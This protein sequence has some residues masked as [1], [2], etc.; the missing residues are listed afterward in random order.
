M[1]FLDLNLKFSVKDN[2]P[3]LCVPQERDY[4]GNLCPVH[5]P[6]ICG[7]NEILCEGHKEAMGCKMPAI[8]YPKGMKTKGDDRMAFFF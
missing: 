6:G 8:C 2:K 4:E 7:E 3:D 1:I 5:C